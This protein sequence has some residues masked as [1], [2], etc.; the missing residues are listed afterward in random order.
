MDAGGGNEIIPGKW[1]HVVA[2]HDGTKDKIFINGTLANSK[3]VAGALNDTEF[4]LGIGFDAID[5]GSFF[6]GN[7]DE[8]QIYNY[9][10]SDQ[11]VAELYTSQSTFT[12]VSSYR[13]ILFI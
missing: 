1:T 3:D 12:G 6:D 13:S 7:I 5:N 2:I 9:A 8:V 10:M 11:D 4:P